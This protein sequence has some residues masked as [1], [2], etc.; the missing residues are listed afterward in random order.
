M[1]GR[2]ESVRLIKA[3]AGDLYGRGMILVLV[4]GRSTAC[5]AVSA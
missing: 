3:A 4:C 2:R 5:F 1:M